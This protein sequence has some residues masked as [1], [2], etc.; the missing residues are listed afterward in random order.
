[1][2]DEYMKLLRICLKDEK[3]KV[4][5][6]IKNVSKQTTLKDIRDKNEKKKIT[7]DYHF[8]DAGNEIGSDIEEDYCVSDILGENDRIYIKRKMTKNENEFSSVQ[9]S[10]NKENL[11]KPDNSS[12]K[13]ETEK[14]ESSNPNEN[15]NKNQANEDN[16]SS[17]E[18]LNNNN[19]N[20]KKEININEIS[21]EG[22]NNLNH[23]DS[24]DNN[25]HEK[26]ESINNS[27]EI[28][29]IPSEKEKRD[30][31]SMRENLNEIKEYTETQKEQTDKDTL[32]DGKGTIEEDKKIEEEKK[33]VG[34]KEKFGENQEIKN[35]IN[36]DKTNENNLNKISEPTSTKINEKFLFFVVIINN[37]YSDKI[38]IK[39][40][41]KNEIITLETKNKIIPF[42]E[43]KSNDP[44]LNIQRTLYFTE[45]KI[46]NK[47]ENIELILECESENFSQQKDINLIY[48]KRFIFLKIAPLYF[49]LENNKII[50]LIKNIEENKAFLD[51]LVL[52]FK[53]K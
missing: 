43:L 39:Y 25:I 36:D 23:N 50:F 37:E 52:Y 10:S 13:E 48:K 29:N 31:V 15:F 1:M 49:E 22:S 44:A 35:A 32:I 21:E 30:E 41:Y 19:I 2:S 46:P 12:P 9:I 11:I 5:C 3:D 7:S 33:N 6:I 24:T 34:K 28:N 14:N 16:I 47:Y 8:F 27:K 17:N 38:N 18:I 51:E 53:N 26:E 20:E 42:L 40:K 45:V 4:F